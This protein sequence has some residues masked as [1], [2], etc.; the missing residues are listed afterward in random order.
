MKQNNSQKKQQYNQPNYLK[1]MIIPTVMGLCLLVTY[2]IT[3]DVMVKILCVFITFSILIPFSLQLLQL[4]LVMISRTGIDKPRDVKDV[5][6]SQ[7]DNKI[8]A[9]NFIHNSNKSIVTQSKRITNKGK[10]N[11]SV[12]YPRLRD[13]ISA[14]SKNKLFTRQD[15]LKLKSEIDYCLGARR[16]IYDN[17]FIFEN[18]LHEIYIKIKS[19][20]LKDKDYERL[21]QVVNEIV[22]KNAEDVI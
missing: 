19:S 4:L 1:S 11:S 7:N 18:D 20:A 16:Y 21:L 2:M 5:L 3:K 10:T 22:E 12:Y 17:N 8:Y 13:S 6:R 15:I 14:C 9:S